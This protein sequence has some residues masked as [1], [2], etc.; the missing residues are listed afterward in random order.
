M[1]FDGLA[2]VAIGI[3]T[4]RLFEFIAD[5]PIAPLQQAAYLYTGIAFVESVLSLYI[6]PGKL[7]PGEGICRD[8]VIFPVAFFINSLLPS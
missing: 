7:L 6:P 2:I 1:S 5:G 3:S 8:P 4:L